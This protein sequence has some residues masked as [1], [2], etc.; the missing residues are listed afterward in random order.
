MSNIKFYTVVVL[1]RALNE[2]IRATTSL[3]EL[4]QLVSEQAHRMSQ[5]NLA[6]M[7]Q[8]VPQVRTDHQYNIEHVT[9]CMYYI[10]V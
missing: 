7:I 5:I 8:R 6:V 10:T 2:R 3:A 1:C 9:C 4:R